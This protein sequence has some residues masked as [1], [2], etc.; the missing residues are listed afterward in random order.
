MSHRHTKPPRGPTAFYYR[1]EGLV[2]PHSCSWLAQSMLP[3]QYPRRAFF[4]LLR[5]TERPCGRARRV[6]AHKANVG[7]AGAS[8]SEVSSRTVQRTDAPSRTGLWNEIFRRKIWGAGVCRRRSTWGDFRNLGWF[9]Q[10][11]CASHYF[12]QR[13]NRHVRHIRGKRARGGG[14]LCIADTSA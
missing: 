2:A 1:I 6:L 13:C 8:A 4:W 7:A 11:P 10:C 5:F 12:N 9:C 3:H 14:T